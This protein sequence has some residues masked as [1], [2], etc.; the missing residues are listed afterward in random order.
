VPT[1]CHQVR[2]ASGRKMEKNFRH[3]TLRWPDRA[4]DRTSEAHA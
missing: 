2:R 1:Y 3:G 4:Y